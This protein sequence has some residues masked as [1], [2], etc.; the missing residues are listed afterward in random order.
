MYVYD[1]DTG[2]RSIE[3]NLVERLATKI[4]NA[5]KTQD[6]LLGK[7]Q[8]VQLAQHDH[9]TSQPSTA[10]YSGILT[11]AAIEVVIQD[12]LF[13][14][15]ERLTNIEKHLAVIRDVSNVPAALTQNSDDSVQSAAPVILKDANSTPQ[16]TPSVSHTLE[17]SDIDDGATVDS[18]LANNQHAA[19]DSG[20]NWSEPTVDV[21]VTANPV[22]KIQESSTGF[23]SK[24]LAVLQCLAIR[25][26]CAF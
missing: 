23:P 11:L 4:G 16:E 12:A 18:R 9:V 20:K 26:P 10:S 15:L 17:P 5:I 24:P 7:S 8:N 13:P 21:C 6:V 1:N 25:L 14:L 3:D 2:F 19:S 22:I